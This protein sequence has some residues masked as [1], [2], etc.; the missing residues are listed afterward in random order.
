MRMDKDAVYAHGRAGLLDIRLWWP[1]RIWYDAG[2][3][4]VEWLV[5][6]DK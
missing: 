6:R 5:E 3:S 1:P 2:G 4:A